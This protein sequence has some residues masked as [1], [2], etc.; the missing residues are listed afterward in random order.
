[1]SGREKKT[2]LLTVRIRTD[3]VTLFNQI[4]KGLRVFTETALLLGVGAVATLWDRFEN[5]IL[6]R[7]AEQTGETAPPETGT[8]EAAPAEPPSKSVKLR[9]LPIDN[10]R[11]LSADQV[12]SRLKKFSGD[13]LELIRQYESTHKKRKSVLEAISRMNPEAK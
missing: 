10:Y 12:I 5:M 2:E 3:E 4:L 8:V 9:L 1:L 7:R 11:L 6:S 13:D